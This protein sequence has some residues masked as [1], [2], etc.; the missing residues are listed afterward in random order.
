MGI[1]GVGKSY[2]IREV[3]GYSEV[4]VSG[5]L[6]SS[7]IRVQPYSFEYL[8]ERITLVDTPGFNDTNRTD[9][10]VL[11]EIADWTSKTYKKNQLLSGIIY[12]H[13]ITHTRMEGSAMR[14]LRMFQKLCGQQVLE[15]VLLTTTQWSNVNPA[16]GQAREDGLRD[17]GLWGG[18]ISKGATLQ[19]FYGTR[20]SGLELINVLV[21]RTRK[22]LHI[23]DQIVKQRMTLLETDAGRFLNEELAAQEKALKERLVSLESR[24]QE[25]MGTVGTVGCGLKSLM[26]EQAKSQKKLEMA[27]A[28]MK[29][30]AACSGGKIARSENESRK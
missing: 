6:Y 28:G 30:L 26:E 18:L 5:G 23:Q 1:T 27:E 21:S 14:N 3:T 22:P 16:E 17:E 2:F 9:T 11:K 19:R 7:T 8:G 24:F 10:E 13:P 12:L 25:A 29:L 20:E 4:N 15:N